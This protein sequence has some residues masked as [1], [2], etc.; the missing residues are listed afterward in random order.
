[1][2]SS[3]RDEREAL[4]QAYVLAHQVFS[5]GLTAAVPAGIG[6]WCDRRWGTAPWLLIVGTVLGF[7]CMLSE[8]IGLTRPRAPNDKSG[9]RPDAPES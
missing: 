8:L 7:V 6:Y 2:G 4:A 1:M 3:R 9:S 5:I